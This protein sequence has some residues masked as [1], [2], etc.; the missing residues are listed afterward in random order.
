M[1]VSAHNTLSEKS[2]LKWLIAI[3]L[4]WAQFAY[5]DHQLAHEA[6]S[7]D[8]PCQICATCEQLENALSD[9]VYVGALPAAAHN[10]PDLSGGDDVMSDP[11]VYGARASP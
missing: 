9:A 8:E 10:V 5:A 7:I 11:R 4:L 1:I 2:A 3:G 6:D